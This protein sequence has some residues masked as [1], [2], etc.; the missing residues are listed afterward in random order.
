MS[1]LHP[2]K[3]TFGPSLKLEDKNTSCSALVHLL[4]LTVIRE[5]D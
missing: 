3:Q 5:N 4:E 2:E 1:Y